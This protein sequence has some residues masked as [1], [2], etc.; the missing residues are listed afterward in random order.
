MG[1]ADLCISYGAEGTMMTFLLEGTP[2]LISPWHVETFMAGRKF[3]AA[4]FGRS[5]ETAPTLGA[6]KSIIENLANDLVLRERVAAFAGLHRK[7]KGH[8][9]LPT[10]MDF[11]RREPRPL[12]MPQTRSKLRRGVNVER[13]YEQTKNAGFSGET[14]LSH[15]CQESVATR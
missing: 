9:P 2:Q 8:E 5:L 10:V 14:L 6:T 11:L 1:R 13:A 12:V 3:E 7:V 15:S 4:G